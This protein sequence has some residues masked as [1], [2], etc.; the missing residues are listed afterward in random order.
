MR[1]TNGT[2]RERAESHTTAAVA[3]SAINGRKQRH[4]APVPRA[5][6]Q[7]AVALIPFTSRREIRIMLNDLRN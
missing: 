6:D 2:T 3:T 1:T 7:I 5:A 4:R